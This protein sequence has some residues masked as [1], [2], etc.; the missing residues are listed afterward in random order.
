MLQPLVTLDP[1]YRTLGSLF[2][3]ESTSGYGVGTGY[4]RLARGT[5]EPRTSGFVENYM[6]RKFQD[7]RVRGCLGYALA[8]REEMDHGEAQCYGQG[9]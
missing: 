5:G 6:I 2:L 4:A 9:F 7:Q 8:H 1:R 3:T